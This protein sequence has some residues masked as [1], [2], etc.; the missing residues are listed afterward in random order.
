[1]TDNRTL[2]VILEL[3]NGEILTF[4]PFVEYGCYLAVSNNVLYSTAMLVCGA[5]DI[6]TEADDLLELN[7]NEVTAPEDQEFLDVVNKHFGTKFK[8]DQFPGR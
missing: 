7:F 6:S 5:P 4:F 3:D 1:M 8:L 2:T